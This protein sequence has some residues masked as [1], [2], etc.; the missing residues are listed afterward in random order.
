MPLNSEYVPIAVRASAS[1]RTSQNHS[2][3][4]FWSPKCRLNRGSSA[5][6]SRSVPTMSKTRTGRMN[7]HPTETA[8]CA[9]LPDR[10]RSLPACRFVHMRPYIDKP[11]LQTR[12]RHAQHETNLEQIDQKDA[13]QHT[14]LFK[15]SCGH[16]DRGANDREPSGS[17]DSP[18]QLRV[19]K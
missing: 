19:F 8:R 5:D 11:V 15:P 16:Y 4:S 1:F 14:A 2:F 10:V 9:S 18:D 6:R 17:L 7:P 13:V 12:W 3:R